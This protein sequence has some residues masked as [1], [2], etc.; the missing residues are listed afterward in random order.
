MTQT[1]ERLVFVEAVMGTVV[2]LEV[3]GAA[4]A[5]GVVEDCFAWLR[6]V[7]ATFSTYRP[8]S[9]V[10]RFA[11]GELVEPSADLRW[12]LDRCEALKRATDGYFDAYATGRFDPSALVKGWAVQRAADALHAGGVR[13]F[14][15]GAGGDLVVRGPSWRIG[16]QH[17]E[18]RAAIAAVAEIQRAGA[19]AT[20]GAYERG[21]H[22]VDPLS[23]MA[24]P[25]VLSVT[26]VGPDLGTADAYATAAFAMGAAGPRWTAKLTGYEAMTILADGTVLSTAG[27]PAR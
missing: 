24:P 9:E 21:A 17:P 15:L 18:D 20:S 14:C 26:V 12:V 5:A 19:V 2:S 8:D 16:I 22:I 27:F 6:R 13:D 7:D 23:G 25:G 10:C 11:R 1:T 3:R 4:P